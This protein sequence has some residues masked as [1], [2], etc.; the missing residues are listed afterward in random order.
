M[1]SGMCVVFSRA[2][3]DDADVMGGGV[4]DDRETFARIPLSLVE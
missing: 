2:V 3:V 4:L 1:R